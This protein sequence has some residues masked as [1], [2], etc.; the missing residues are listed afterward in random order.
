M[1]TESTLNV[2]TVDVAIFA[3]ITLS[4]IISVIRGFIKETMSIVIWLSAFFIAVSFKSVISDYL[5]NVITLP[6]IRQM[7]AWG[8]LFVSTLLLGSLLSFVLGKLVSST[9]LSGTDKTLGLV[10]GVFRGF[11]IVLAIVIILPELVPVASD[12]WW[13]ESKLIPFFQSFESVGQELAT[14]I[15]NK[16]IEWI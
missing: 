5:I 2:A 15:I 13:T 3:L 9:G 14:L 10:F 8:I 7:T 16:I 11:L 6:S 1:I 4:G 12:Q